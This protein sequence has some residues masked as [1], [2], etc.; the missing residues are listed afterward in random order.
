MRNIKTI[1]AQLKSWKSLLEELYKEMDQEAEP[2]GG[3]I[4][5]QYADLIMVCEEKIE[6]LEKELK[7]YIDENTS[8]QYSEEQLWKDQATYNERFCD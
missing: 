2:E 5:D 7:P 4:A 8:E 1:E 6:N 3:L